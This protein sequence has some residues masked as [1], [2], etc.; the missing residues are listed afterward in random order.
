L[1]DDILEGV[2][3]YME[4]HDLLSM[5]PISLVLMKLIVLVAGSVPGAEAR[6]FAVV[7]LNRDEDS[8]FSYKSRRGVFTKWKASYFFIQ[9]GGSNKRLLY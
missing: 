5:W 9:K 8:T 2:E 3:N 4:S 6:D 1:Q 7:Y